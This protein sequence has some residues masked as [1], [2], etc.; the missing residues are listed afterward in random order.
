MLDSFLDKTITLIALL[1]NID[2]CITCFFFTQYAKPLNETNSGA[3]CFQLF[4]LRL[5]FQFK[6]SVF[7]TIFAAF[8]T[9]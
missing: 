2:A 9:K 1:I 8:M 4:N 6:D 7:S 5:R 3:L